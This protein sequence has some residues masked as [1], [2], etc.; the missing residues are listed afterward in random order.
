MPWRVR[1][2]PGRR[3]PRGPANGFR[4]Q[5]P[6]G[7]RPGAPHSVAPP[8]S[9]PRTHRKRC[10]SSLPMFWCIRIAPAAIE[11]ERLF[12]IPICSGSGLDCAE[13]LVY[14][15]E[16][17]CMIWR[18]LLLFPI[19]NTVQGLKRRPLPL[20]PRS[21]APGPT[22]SDNASPPS[23]FGNSRSAPSLGSRPPKSSP[24]LGFEAH[25]ARKAALLGLLFHLAPRCE[26]EPR[27]TP[28]SRKTSRK[29]P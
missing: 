2:R 18:L 5:A 21:A 19:H 17:C 3:A 15:L 26:T 20:S 24:R 27:P 8:A 14:S 11:C 9:C 10:V 16:C 23:C 29:A 1:L 7:Q 6:G 12:R 22:T 28:P 4:T 13:H 25:S